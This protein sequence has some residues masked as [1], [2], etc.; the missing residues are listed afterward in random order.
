MMTISEIVMSCLKEC[1][2][3]FLEHLIIK[4]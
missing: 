2:V 3:S 4:D 1:K